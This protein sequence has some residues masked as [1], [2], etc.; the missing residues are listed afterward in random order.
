MPPKN[1]DFGPGR[2]GRKKKYKV[3]GMAGRGS[4]RASGTRPPICPKAK[5]RPPPHEDQGLGPIKNEPAIYMHY[6]LKKQKLTYIIFH[7]GIVYADK[8]K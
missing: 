6:A 2:A 3:K 7:G 4:V 8:K 5:P 1:R